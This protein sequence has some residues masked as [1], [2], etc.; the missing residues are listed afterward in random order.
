M[1]LD[2][3]TNTSSPSKSRLHNLSLFDKS[4]DADEIMQRDFVMLVTDYLL[5]MI[6]D[7]DP[8]IYNAAMSTF[9]RLASRVFVPR[10]IE[11]YDCIGPAML[12][13]L[14]IKIVVNR[15]IDYKAI[16]TLAAL[17][18]CFEKHSR[19]TWFRISS[20]MI[21]SLQFVW[22]TPTSSPVA[23]V[24]A[25][26]IL[27]FILKIMYVENDRDETFIID[28]LLQ[29]A[30]N[31][32][33]PAP[34]RALLARAVHAII[35][36]WN[37]ADQA[38]RDSLFKVKDELKYEQELMAFHENEVLTPPLTTTSA[39]GI[40]RND[41]SSS[42]PAMHTGQEQCTRV[43]AI[44]AIAA[45]MI[46]RYISTINIDESANIG[47]TATASSTTR[48]ENHAMDSDIALLE[49]FH[50]IMLAFGYIMGSKNAFTPAAIEELCGH[51][52]RFLM[53]Y[54]GKCSQEKKENN[55]HQQPLST[56][57]V[58]K[59]H[60]SMDQS[61]ETRMEGLSLAP[62]EEKNMYH[63]Q[64]KHVMY[65]G[66]SL[67]QFTLARQDI[68]EQTSVAGVLISHALSWFQQ[69]EK[70]P[71]RH[72]FEKAM[73]ET[74]C[75]P[76]IGDFGVGCL[77]YYRS[78]T[79]AVILQ[80]T[81]RFY[82]HTVCLDGGSNSSFNAL[83]DELPISSI[84]PAT[85]ALF[86]MNVLLAA[87]RSGRIEQTQVALVWQ[88]ACDTMHVCYSGITHDRKIGKE[89][90]DK[91]KA[92]DVSVFVANSVENGTLATL[93]Q[94]IQSCF[95]ACIR[96]QRNQVDGA[97]QET[98]TAEML[99]NLHDAMKIAAEMIRML[100]VLLFSNSSVSL[101]E[102]ALAWICEL[103]P[104]VQKLPSW[105]S[106]FNTMYRE[107]AVDDDKSMKWP[108]LMHAIMSSVMGTIFKCHALVD[109]TG[110][111]A[112][113]K[114]IAFDA[115][116]GSCG[117]VEAASSTVVAKAHLAALEVLIALAEAF[118]TSC[119]LT[120]DS[121][122]MSISIA[123]C[124]IESL[125]SSDKS[126]SVKAG[127]LL[128]AVA[129]MATIAV[130]HWGLG[131]VLQ[132]EPFKG[133]KG[134]TAL[135][136]VDRKV[137]SDHQRAVCAVHREAAFG[138]QSVAWTTS[139]LSQIL[140][141]CTATTQSTVLVGSSQSQK[142]AS[143]DVDEWLATFLFG[144]SMA[145]KDTKDMP[146]DVASFIRYVDFIAIHFVFHHNSTV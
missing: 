120:R 111:G 115:P 44:A 21:Y 121:S 130:S 40:D 27:L 4:I 93:L 8:V 83:V 87:V 136:D 85:V 72:E 16:R 59:K 123:R 58:E 37:P 139:Q 7:Q 75:D 76:N 124:A 144:I 39:D 97:I 35:A 89:I 6:C 109:G 14:F 63:E 74:M 52:N 122:F 103:F 9:S 48:N 61:V 56:K 142:K 31:P 60:V 73:M 107:Y 20:K 95:V 100:Q 114:A 19:K 50:E 133:D 138:G 128:E 36:D 88:R 5:F 23:I 119:P 102:K 53:A 29:C 137:M 99:S 108:S 70:I 78:L 11:K 106:L 116:G 71:I 126:I 127:K 2:E 24:T 86:N 66:L 104:R 34:A 33:T 145:K 18:M 129:P 3:A 22:G 125:H 65:Q 15:H 112:I 13:A 10:S 38:F 81:A 69:F 57:D 51:V 12:D 45:P 67:I 143:L 43:L 46:L 101:A 64:A 80:P 55:I 110:T 118:F 132:M 47:T 77:S 25:L 131:A 30:R 113:T 17:K 92:T 68:R 105:H 96:Q 117:A 134:C 42:A 84:L 32:N 49:L 90:D 146:L 79:D 141:Y 41:S 1:Y 135:R 62:K 28:S 140:D 26:E 91:T 98:E 54:L 94:L 82:L